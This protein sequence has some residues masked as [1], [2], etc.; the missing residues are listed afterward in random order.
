MTSYRDYK[1]DKEWEWLHN[2]SAYASA[3]KFEA[4]ESD[5]TGHKLE[6]IVTSEWKSKVWATAV[7]ISTMHSNIDDVITGQIK[8]GK[9]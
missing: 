4:S 8:S 7:L 6:M 2:D 3:L 1:N 5:P 9:W